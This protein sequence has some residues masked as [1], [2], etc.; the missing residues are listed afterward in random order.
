MRI[1]ELLTNFAPIKPLSPSKYGA[2]AKQRE[3]ER[4][5]QSKEAEK[6]RERQ[7]TAAERQVAATRRAAKPIVRTRHP[8]PAKSAVQ[9]GIGSRSR[10]TMRR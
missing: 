5:K 10:Q 1:V 2:H 3:R 6:E 4:E 9:R 8:S 7:Q